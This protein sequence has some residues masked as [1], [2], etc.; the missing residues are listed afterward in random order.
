[1][2]APLRTGIA[3]YRDI[4]VMEID[5]DGLWPDD[6]QIEWSDPDTTAAARDERLPG[7]T[8]TL[9]DQGPVVH[10]ADA[11]LPAHSTLE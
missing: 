11:T 4:G 6:S 3:L 7:V 9:S 5:P 8:A 2:M 1:M 10:S